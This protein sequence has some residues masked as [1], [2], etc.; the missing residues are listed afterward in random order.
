MSKKIV[1]SRSSAAAADQL[2]ASRVALEQ[3]RQQATPQTAAQHLGQRHLG[4]QRNE[5]RNELRILRGL[6]DQRQLH[7]RRGHLH[8]GLG[9]LILRAIHDV[10]PVNQVRHRRRVE[11]ERVDAMCARKLV[12]EV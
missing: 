11:A 1:P 12:H 3:R 9:A 4:Q 5:P 8:G 7:R 10:G 6:D 2:D